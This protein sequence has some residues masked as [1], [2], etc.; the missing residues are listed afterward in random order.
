MKTSLM[1]R[2]VSLAAATS[3]T[4]SGLTVLADSALPPTQA[5]QMA[6]A[7]RSGALLDADKQ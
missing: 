3:V 6:A 7:S 5:A 2:I 4:L 1:T